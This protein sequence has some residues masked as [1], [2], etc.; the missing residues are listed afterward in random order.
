MKKKKV[1][2]VEDEFLISELYRHYLLNLGH[3]VL[4]TFSNGTDAIAF[5]REN[6]ADLV[7]MDVKL[8]NSEDGIDTMKKINEFR[9]IPVVYISGNTEDDNLKR[10]L[11]TELMAFLSKPIAMD[12]LDNILGSL[13]DINSSILYAERIQR[14]IFPQRKEISRILPGA[15]FINRP[16]HLVNGDFCFVSKNRTRN[17]ITAG[18]GDCAG[19]GVPAALLSVMSHEM[20]RS[21]AR[22]NL[23]PQEIIRHLNHN[24]VRN[25]ARVDRSRKLNDYLDLLVFRIE[26]DLQKIT[27]ADIRIPYVR[28][29]AETGEMEWHQYEGP[30]IGGGFILPGQI[31]IRT[32]TYKEGD[33][34]FFFT[35]GIP[36]LHGGEEGKKLKKEG[37]MEAIRKIIQQNSSAR[38]IEFDMMLRKWQGGGIAG[39]DMIL[40]GFSPF[41]IQKLNP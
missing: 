25:L 4:A 17:W 28:Y 27:I 29:V 38:D 22:R 35:D 8:G 3:E 14:A 40:L 6:T 5:F 30:R 37:L 41:E 24:I 2:I 13:K 1:V 11:D 9:D 10:A 34:F 23:E 12:D 26:A 7:L 32:Y 31:A 21:L 36:D 15:I 18:I 33:Y 20:L 19:H 16:R 39:D